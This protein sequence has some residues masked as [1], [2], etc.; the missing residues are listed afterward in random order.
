MRCW[1]IGANLRWLMRSTEWPKD[2]IYADMVRM[3]DTAFR[4][5]VRGTRVTDIL[6][7][8][9][10]RAS[11]SF[12]YDGKKE[13]RLASHVYDA[14]I[15]FVNLT[16]PIP[17]RSLLDGTSSGLPRLPSTGQPVS[18]M[19]HDG[20]RFATPAAGLRDSYVVFRAPNNA[21]LAGQ[22]SDIF[23]HQ[24]TKAGNLT[25]EPFLVVNTFKVLTPE[26]AAHDPYRQFRDLDAHLVYNNFDSR[27]QVISLDRVVSHFA[28][29]KY[30]PEGIDRECVVVRSLD[31]VRSRSYPAVSHL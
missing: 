1:Y 19:E 4:E 26:H 27:P 28:F 9:D 10:N 16:S 8:L 7:A 13:V 20:V 11:P 29:Y 24:R 3:Y 21:V 17:Y 15:S 2:P 14:L 18:S 6:H 5:R 30:E 12:A 23:Y 25:V 31:R 22:I